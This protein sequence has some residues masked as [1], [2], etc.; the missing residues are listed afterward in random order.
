M[1]YQRY[2]EEEA[3]RFPPTDEWVPVESTAVEAIAYR[4][5]ISTL[6]VKLR[7]GGKY[8]F[9]NVSRD[10]FN[11]F[12][13]APSKGGF[14]SD[15]VR[16]YKE[17]RVMLKTG[18]LSDMTLKWRSKGVECRAYE[19]GDHIVLDHLRVPSELRGG[20]LGS[21]FMKELCDYA[22]SVGK[23]IELTL[24]PKAPGETTS[25]GRLVD[26]YKG[27]G[28]MENRGRNIDY[29]RSCSMYRPSV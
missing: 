22:D 10:L 4:D 13:A 7:N 16:K 11:Q 26:F 20:G 6:E 19:F 8:S 21:E 25:R 2:A 12:L 24:A 3:S 28:F 27:F 17:N 1:W 15:L 9:S 14:F 23:R 29:S 18:L 5:P